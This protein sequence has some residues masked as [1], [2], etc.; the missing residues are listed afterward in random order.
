MSEIW[1]GCPDLG[2]TYGCHWAKPTKDDL[3]YQTILILVVFK[4]GNIGGMPPPPPPYIS[5][6]KLISNR[7]VR[8]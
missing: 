8:N 4:K 7:D 6:L 3:N 5:C 1:A 2:D